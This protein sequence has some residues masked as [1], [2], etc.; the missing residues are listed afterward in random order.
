[1]AASDGG[2]TLRVVP[3]TAVPGSDLVPVLVSVRPPADT[4]VQRTPVDV[5]LVLDISGSMGQEATIQGADGGTESNGLT[6]LDVAKHG[7]RTVV[8][9]LT[10]QD[11]FALV[12]FN[13]AATVKT[14]LTVMDEAGQKAVEESL[15]TFNSGGGTDIW[16]GLAGAL[17]EVQ[18]AAP[19]D[20]PR[21]S[22]ILLLTDGESQNRDS[23]VPNL[24]AYKQQK[25]RLPATVST[26]GFGYSI[27]SALLI[28]LAACG[29]GTY[30]FIPDVG[31]VGTVF[32][33]TLSNLLVT[34]A[35]ET[36]LSLG[37]EGGAE[38]VSVRGG[39]PC[40]Q[41]STGVTVPIGTLQYSQ[42]KDIVVMMRGVTDEYLCA[43][44]TFEGVAGV[45]CNVAPVFGEAEA[46]PVAV[47]VHVMRALFV[48]TL[49]KLA[50]GVPPTKAKQTCIEATACGGA[51]QFSLVEETDVSDR[52]KG[53]HLVSELVE[54]VRGCLAKDEE[55]VKNLLEDISGQAA[56][57]LCRDDWWRKWGRHYMPSLM[58]AHMSQQC[59]NFKD[60]G[61]Q[62]YGG[63][64]FRKVRDS[65]D[66]LFNQL[67]APKPS[68]R[69][70]L[71]YSAPVNM[72]SYNNCWGG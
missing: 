5:V 7:V 54:K 13:D 14:R 28:D 65:A 12:L 39:Y 48:E 58:L 10:A 45:T 53:A 25:E 55:Q 33:N 66:E 46:Q 51:S 26:F 59:N 50:A 63:D 38:I 49:S 17:N 68:G 18:D 64:L 36:V 27:D 29:E 9:S 4:G 8:K 34:M 42:P 30:S 6:L 43:S 35:R 56:E 23:I 32:V 41:T 20:P 37:V 3:G 24:Q 19:H 21:L 22:H 57:A 11:R 70:R 47:E 44:A 1:M 16:K 72:A 2:V 31:F 15:D 62:G 52:E 61:V 67:P 40:M 69:A 71:S 60:P